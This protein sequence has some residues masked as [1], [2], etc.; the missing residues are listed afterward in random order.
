MI[1]PYTS[2][3]LVIETPEVTEAERAEGIAANEQFKLNVAWWNARVNELSALHMGKYV[4][5][6]GQEIF[7]GDDPIE[8]TQRARAAHPTPGSGFLCF[9][10]TTRQGPMIH[11]S[12]R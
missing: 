3:E 1:R 11:A 2:S 9:R 5:V 12:P 7:A 8:V 4:C 6:A 10:I